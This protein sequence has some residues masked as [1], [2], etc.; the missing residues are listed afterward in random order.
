[1]VNKDLSSGKNLSELAIG[2]FDSGLGGVSVL[3][4]ISELMPNET[5]IYYGDSAFAPYGLKS[6][7]DVINRVFNVVDEL[8]ARGIKALV[9]ACNTAT[10]VAVTLLREKYDMPILGLEPALKPAIDAGKQNVLVLATEITIR[11]TKFANLSKKFEDKALIHKV[12][13]S[14]LVDIVESDNI[15]VDTVKFALQDALKTE[16]IKDYDAV[17]LGCTHFIF[18]K[19]EIQ[20]LIPHAT[21]FDGNIGVTEH[22]KALL[23]KNN[24]LNTGK[25]RETL[26]LSSDSAMIE[27]FKKYAT[28]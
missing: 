14:R 5:L 6:S 20:N 2:V 18:A 26:F 8:V 15:N 25:K 11:E 13:A 27:R 22:L 28:R 9:I 19:D 1:M 17:V 7:E 12:P 10:S 23:T 4:T 3:N 21:I 24:L 16:R